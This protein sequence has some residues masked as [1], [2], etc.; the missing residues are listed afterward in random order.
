MGTVNGKFI[1][2]LAFQQLI[3]HMLAT[4][5]VAHHHQDLFVIFA[6]DPAQ[7]NVRD[8]LRTVLVLT[9]NL[10]GVFKNPAFDCFL[11]NAPHLFSALQ[12]VTEEMLCQLS[13]NFSLRKTEDP[14]SRRIDRLDYAIAIHS[15]DGI[16]DLIPYRVGQ[17]FLIL[18]SNFQ[19]S[20]HDPPD[21]WRNNDRCSKSLYNP[22]SKK[23][24][25]TKKVGHERVFQ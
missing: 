16:D 18:G 7:R 12:M 13:G 4:A 2:L 15:Q 1:T 14:L 9:G 6:H 5:Y 20:C 22:V 23:I 11:D 8:Q 17:S 24:P 10:E 3:L 21:K 25:V 19:R